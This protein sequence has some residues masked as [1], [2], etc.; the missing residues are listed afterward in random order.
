MKER[1]TLPDF[2][3]LWRDHV[4]ASQSLRMKDDS[5][6]Q[7]FWKAFMKTRS[8]SPDASSRQVLAYLTPIFEEL[9]IETALEFGP[10]WGNYTLDLAKLCREVASVDISQD[11]LDFILQT[12][13]EHDFENLR[14]IHSKWEDFV[15]DRKYDLVF[16]YN[17]FY[18]H[19]DLA[20]CF[21][22]MNDSANTLCVVGMNT[23]LAPRWVHDL[24][25]AGG[26]VSWEWKDYVYFPGVLYQMGIDANVRILPFEKQLSY[27]NEETLVSG[28]LRRCGVSDVNPT[29]AAPILR[30]YFT[31]EADGSFHAA[32]HFR[33]AVVWWQ[34]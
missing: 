27:E 3:K 8:Y 34:P 7:D 10:G 29:L 26:K 6:E 33:S 1:V 24:E 18:R 28:E 5:A 31:E 22:K 13:R 19:A 30:K 15:P 4:L 21:R 20:A 16:G 11:V 9:G 25:E 2:K 17:C 14:G 23:G 12:G 32:A